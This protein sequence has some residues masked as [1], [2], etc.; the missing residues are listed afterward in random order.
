MT[1]DKLIATAEGKLIKLDKDKKAHYIP[2]TISE[3]PN[4][5]LKFRETNVIELYEGY[6][7][8]RPKRDDD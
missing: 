5:P 3:N 7:I 6:I 1:D 4:F 8:I 2:I